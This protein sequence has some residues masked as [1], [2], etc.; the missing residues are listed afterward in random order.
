MMATACNWKFYFL[1]D[2]A[3]SPNDL[4][5]GFIDANSPIGVTNIRYIQKYPRICVYQIISS[6]PSGDYN[7][8]GQGFLYPSQDK[9][10]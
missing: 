7:F 9:K 3:K 4:N 6:I 8:G 1:T 10:I 2:P 5:T